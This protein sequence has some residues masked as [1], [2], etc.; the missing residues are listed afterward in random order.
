MDI[1]I[2]FKNGKTSYYKNVEDITWS[3]RILYIDVKQTWNESPACDVICIERSEIAS[4]TLKERK[5]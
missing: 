1:S 4:I 3:D 5:V 2:Y